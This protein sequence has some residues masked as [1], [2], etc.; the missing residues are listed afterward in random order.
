MKRFHSIG[1]LLS[2][3]TGLLVV[4]LV[5]VFALSTKEAYERKQDA[6]RLLSAVHIEQNIL[7]AKQ[8]IRAEWSTTNGAFAAA[9]DNGVA[10]AGPA[11]RARI[12]RLHASTDSAVRQVLEEIHSGL[13]GGGTAQFQR[14]R[15]AHA[16]YNAA[17]QALAPT[18]QH[19]ITAGSKT[20][21]AN[22]RQ[23][24]IALTDAINKQADLISRDI[25][26]EDPAVNDLIAV[27]NLAW[28][29]VVE[30]GK[31]R[32]AI[33]EAIADRPPPSKD[34]LLRF[35]EATGGV[36]AFWVRIE[37]TANLP[38]LPPELA[39]SI[40]QAAYVYFHRFRDARAG[41]V[42]TLAQGG[43][44]QLSE[45]E[46]LR[47]SDPGLTSLAAI[48][49]SALDLTEAHAAKKA[50][51]AIRN[52]AI[53]I[54][55]ML[56]SIGLAS[57]T[58][59][60]VM[61]RFIRPLKR[62]TQTI[63]TVAGGNLRQEIPFESRDDEIGEFARALRMFRDSA[64]EKLRLETELAHNRAAKETAENSSRLKSEFLAN[65]SHELRTPLNA[66]IGFS[67]I[68]AKE[69]FG[70]GLPRYREYAHDIGG[71][72]R[73]LLSLINDILDISKAEAGK[74]DLRFEPV[75]LGELIRECARLMHER[76][77]QQG[78]RLSLSIGPLPMLLIDRLRIKQVL[79]NLLSNAVKF[80]PQGGS[81]SIEADRDG[82]GRIIVCVRD[83]G[84]GIAQEAVPLAFEPFRQIDSTL[85]RKYEGTG[86]GLALVKNLVELH[87]G[88]VRIESTPGKGTAVFVTF[89]AAR[90]IVA[91]QT[92]L[93]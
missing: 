41:I 14:L 83:T 93:A 86:L 2:A 67:D 28:N 75:D 90:A 47:L 52:F 50:S 51:I 79:L 9:P 44:A 45:R 80:T 61:W 73:H 18:L 25:V 24:V 33:A 32:R 64:A 30:A 15:T 16:R 48:S 29:A 4:M 42:A 23:T 26:S 56:L 31:D 60:Y 7:A 3:I 13:G 39:A 20:A 43:G 46:W 37:E 62:I 59:L 82:A 11:A 58:A 17:F 6:D 84:I 77:A 65:M 78:L 54:A 89:P 53:A 63:K 34:T 35:S 1:T 19:P 12:A 55:L 69:T 10:I 57:F 72:G 38:G 49:K 27:N 81:V 74:L 8:N 70:P 85:S 76:A 40:R 22:W 36:N 88:E 66:I 5:S 71:A 21:L 91:P 87:G 68:I 92:R